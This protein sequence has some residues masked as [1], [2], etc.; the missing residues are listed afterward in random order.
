MG[1]VLFIVLG[2]GAVL[3][4]AYFTYLAK[5]RRQQGLALAARQLGLE[6]SLVDA[7]NT[8]GEPFQLFRK[9]DGRGVE[10]IMWGTWQGMEL[11]EFD[12]WYYEQTSNGKTTSRTYY[13]FNCVMCPIQASCAH[14]KIDHENLFT[15]IADALSFHDIE[16]ESEDFDR[17]YNVKSPDKKFAIDFVDA[18][19][20]Q[21]LMQHADGYAFEVVG[22]RIRCSHKR[23]EPTELIPLIGTAKGFLDHVPRA[24]YELYAEPSATG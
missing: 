4:V 19:M 11:H 22:N 15:R 17:K 1:V 2:A 7:F 10:N 14:L 9:G 12:Y 5:K 8:L 24:V 6:F 13:R 16:F 23:F 20:I 18:R 21:W 3:A